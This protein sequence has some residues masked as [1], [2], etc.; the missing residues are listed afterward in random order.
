VEA[1][2]AG[3]IVW[4]AGQRLPP[5]RRRMYHRVVEEFLRWRDRHPNFVQDP[6]W[7]YYAELRDSGAG[8]ARLQVTRE[9]LAWLARYLGSERHDRDETAPG[10]LGQTIAFPSPRPPGSRQPSR[11]RG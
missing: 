6:A 4:L 11:P 8:E 2:L 5:G 9:A 10:S 1:V 7:G 3:F